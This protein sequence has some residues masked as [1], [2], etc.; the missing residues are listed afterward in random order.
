MYPSFC[1]YLIVITASTRLVRNRDPLSPACPEKY[2][3][4]GQEKSQRKNDGNTTE[5]LSFINSG[6]QITRSFLAGFIG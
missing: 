3:P 6:L 2:E 5:F 1:I 4:S